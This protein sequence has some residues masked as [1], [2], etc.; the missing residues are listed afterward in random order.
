MTKLTLF[1][2]TKTICNRPCE[3]LLGVRFD[4]KLNFDAHINNIWKKASLTLNALARI[5][6][7]MDL[8]KKRVLLHVLFNSQRNYCQLVW[9]YRHRT[10]NKKKINFMKDVLV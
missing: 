5:T 3:Q 1:L 9:M 2:K 7:Y 10:K 4:S 6:L 8:N